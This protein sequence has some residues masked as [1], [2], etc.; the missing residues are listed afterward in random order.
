VDVQ[1]PDLYVSGLTIE[2][3]IS[4]EG[5]TLAL[6]VTAG[7]SGT[8]NATAVTVIIYDNGRKIKEWTMDRMAPGYS[9]LLIFRL[10]LPRGN[11][12]LSAIVSTPD[13]E[14]SSTNNQL[15]GDARVRAGSSF[16]P[17]FGAGALVAAALALLAFRSVARSPASVHQS[18]ISR[19]CGMRK[20]KRGVS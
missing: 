11:H 20:T 7:N 4:D 12:L 19:R 6:R 15:Q 17:A 2:P 1:L 5:G 8:A 9:E 13:R 14:L 10:K 3:Q 16:I 18:S